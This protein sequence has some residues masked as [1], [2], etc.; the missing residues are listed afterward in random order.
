MRPTLWLALLLLPACINVSS[1]RT[2]PEYPPLP[3]DATVLVYWMDESPLYV[4][5]NTEYR[6]DVVPATEIARIEVT[7][8]KDRWWREVVEELKEEARE[9]GGDIVR[10]GEGTSGLSKRNFE[11]I[12]YRSHPE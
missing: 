9:L 5:T 8:G 1:E 12:V 2:G 3:D 10:I 7:Y 6:Y 11:A 4:R